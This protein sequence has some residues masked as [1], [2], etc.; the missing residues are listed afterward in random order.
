MACKSGLAMH[1]LPQDGVVGDA[2]PVTL[3]PGRRDAP[4]PGRPARPSERPCVTGGESPAPVPSALGQP[5]G[6]AARGQPTTAICSR[7]SCTVSSSSALPTRSAFVDLLL[8]D[9]QRRAEAQ[10]VVRHRAADD[11]VL[12][13]QLAPAARRPWPSGRSS[14]A[15][16]CRRPARRRRSGPMPRTS[17]TSG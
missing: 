15:P 14:C 13:A 17:P 16:P 11:A 1:S 10:R 5:P 3:E 4:A 6:S 12:L 2:R 9:D 8:R 7:R